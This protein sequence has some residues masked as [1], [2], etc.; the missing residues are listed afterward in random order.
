MNTRVPEL[1]E[2]GS[3]LPAARTRSMESGSARN[4][5]AN[6]HQRYAQTAPVSNQSHTPIMNKCTH[7]TRRT[8]CGAQ[9][10]T[11]KDWCRHATAV[12][13]KREAHS[14]FQFV[15]RVPRVRVT[16]R[17]RQRRRKGPPKKKR[18]HHVTYRH[19]GEHSALGQEDV[20]NGR[21]RTTGEEEGQVRCAQQ[22]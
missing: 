18:E 20:R 10:T 1:K 15:L 4:Q 14:P 7:Q 22:I 2:C 16:E 17:E 8:N 3:A 11:V 19:R 21:T 9:S 13:L 6:C 5:R 12:S